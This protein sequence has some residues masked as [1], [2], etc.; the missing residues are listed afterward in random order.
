MTILQ[1][2]RQKRS[3]LAFAAFTAFIAAAA[4]ACS[5][6]SS[7]DQAAAPP[8]SAA[9]PLAVGI[10]QGDLGAFLTG[11]KGDT[12]YVFTRDDPNQSNCDAGC[13]KVWPPLLIAEGQPVQ[14]DP[15]APSSFGSISTPSG[16]QVTY[17]DAPLYYYAGDARPGDTKGHLIEGV[18]FVA[19]PDTASTADVGVRRS[20]DGAL[21]VGPTGMSLYVLS[22]DNA[23]VSSCSGQCAMTFPALHTEQGVDPSAVNPATGT[24]G[25]HTRADDG[26]QQI[27]Y[28]GMPLYYF[29]GDQLPGDA[30]GDG[31]GGVWSLAKA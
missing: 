6:G 3:L 11:P 21:L 22:R 5:S 17:N 31:V 30:K 23:G 18:W 24:L 1:N 27:V 10:N 25:V 4:I 28:N 16:R 12:V 14:A 7:D 9:A 20:G 19:R 8:Y 13:L 15:S 2:F 26:T 29:S